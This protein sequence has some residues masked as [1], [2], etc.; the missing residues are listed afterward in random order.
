MSGNQTSFMV[1]SEQGTIALA[2]A[3]SALISKGDVLLLEGDLG[4]GKSFFARALLRAL[5][6]DPQL[7][8]PSPT[9]SLVQ[10]YVFDALTC[11]HA[12]LYRLSDESEAEELGLFDEDVVLIIEWPDRLPEL[13]EREHFELRLENVR[14]EPTKRK[15]NI[16]GEASR[17]KE[18]VQALESHSDVSQL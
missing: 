2:D 18:L 15:I 11:L 7:D 17:L 16:E 4:A 12:D 14:G 3:F 13:R 1:K 8:V 5:V 10:P 6:N 9:F